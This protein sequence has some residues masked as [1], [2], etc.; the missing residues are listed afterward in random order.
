MEYSPAVTDSR[1]IGAAS[2]AEDGDDTGATEVTQAELPAA[3]VGATA[4]PAATGSRPPGWRRGGLEALA[5]AVATVVLAMRAVPA[6]RDGRQTLFQDVLVNAM[7]PDRVGLAKW[8]KDGVFPLWLRGNYGGEPYLANTQH[9]TLYPGNLPFFFLDTAFALEVTIIAHFVVASVAMWAYCRYCLRT[10][11]W[12]GFLAAIAFTLSGS[13]LAHVVLGDQIQVIC[14]MPVVLLTGHLALERRRL[15]WSVACAV[16]IGLA[17]LAGHVEEWLYVMVAL[18][19]YGLAWILFR[20]RTGQVRR[21]GQALL[22]LGGSVALFVVLFSWQLLPALQLRGNGYRTDPSFNQQYPL[23]K[24]TAINALLPDFARTL[25]GENVGF[26]GFAALC[27][28]GLG[29]AARRRDLGWVR[30]WILLTAALGFVYALGNSNAIYRLAYDHV[31]LIRAFRVPS[32]WLLLPSVALPVGAALGLD[33]LLYSHVGRWRNRLTQGVAGLAVLGVGLAGALLFA[34]VVNDGVSW[35]RWALAAAVG[36]LAWLAAGIRR[37]PRAV[38]ALVLLVVTALELVNAR[39]HAEQKQVAPD[40]VY[41]EY[42]GNLQ[43]IGADGGRYIS[44]GQMPKG[45][46]G[47][48]VP[49]PAG[50]TPREAAYFRAGY[51]ERIV[52]RPDTHLGAQAESPLGRDGGFIPLRW[53]RDFYYAAMGGGGDLNSGNVSTPPSRW[54]WASLDLMAVEWFITGDDLPPAE[55]AVLQQHGFRIA[56]QYGYALRWQR[57]GTSLARFV[58]AADVIPGEQQRLAR[59]RA[60]Y[61]LLDRAIVEE[62]VDLPAGGSTAGQEVDVTGVG[63]T[64]VDLAVRTPQRSLLVLGDP[65]YPGWRVEIDGKP[66]DLLR[67]DHAFRGVVVPAGEHHVRFVYVDRRFQLGI[68]LLV[69][70]VLGLAVTPFVA[71]RLRRRGHG[72]PTGPAATGHGPADGDPAAGRALD[73]G[74]EPAGG[75]PIDRIDADSGTAATAIPGREGTTRTDRLRED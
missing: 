3:P 71:S 6:F 18:A 57:D 46:Q 15:R 55:R 65:W 8:L 17:F 61:P 58:Q 41:S 7:A 54:N 72:D 47:K 5:I 28:V 53:Y 32:R 70:T 34:D 13:T 31:A 16:A 67:V 74:S 2:E 1:T 43:A 48:E 9:G 25:V 22:T 62:P 27:L 10:S 45:P 26:T 66:A 68:G 59:L 35:K 21:L 36:G 51:W 24:A 30:A 40:A 19:L 42:G 37:V 38:P 52:G 39:P 50:L 49:V 14:L 4:A 73:G 33:E 20:E 64:S 69:L 56:G 44:I 11:M 63:E 12:A 23:P 75:L 60:G 29:I